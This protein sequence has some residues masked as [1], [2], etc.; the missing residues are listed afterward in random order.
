MTTWTMDQVRQVGGLRAEVTV[1]TELVDKY[2][3]DVLNEATHQMA[4]RITDMAHPFG[5]ELDPSFREDFEV[6]WDRSDA[7]PWQAVGRLRWNPSTHTVEL[8][9]GHLDGQRFQIR[10]VGEEFRVPRPAS[11][12]W[13]DETDVVSSAAMTELADVVYGL[14]GWRED[15]HVWVYEAK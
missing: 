6:V 3:D 13:Y 15:E 9:G 7:T 14:V 8:R 1:D 4:K 11:T 10:T 2:G 12:P 5:V